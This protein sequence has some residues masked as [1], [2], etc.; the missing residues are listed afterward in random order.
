M[1]ALGKGKCRPRLDGN[2]ASNRASW[3]CRKSP[4]AAAAAGKLSKLAARSARAAAR[5]VPDGCEATL[6]S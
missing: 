2:M 1:M 5:I 3:R 4:I 6:F